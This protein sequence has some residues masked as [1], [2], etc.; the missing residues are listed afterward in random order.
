MSQA[1]HEGAVESFTVADNQREEAIQM[2]N[3][4]SIDETVALESEY[5]EQLQRGINRYTASFIIKR[6]VKVINSPLHEEHPLHGLVINDSGRKR[7]LGVTILG[8]RN[9]IRISQKFENN[10][11]ELHDDLEYKIY[12]LKPQLVG[13]LGEIAVF[14]PKREVSG[15][16]YVTYRLDDKLQKLVKNEQNSFLEFFYYAHDINNVPHI[17]MKTT[18]V[19][20]EAQE[21]A[22]L[23]RQSTPDSVA[24]FLG[25]PE[26]IP[27]SKR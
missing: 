9:A 15:K 23:L 25:P 19:E 21:Y 2:T 5:Y 10:L 26:I 1:Y 16:R 12:S 20:D 8:R 24:I 22:N 11:V 4:Q 17:T 3:E 18:Y 6:P 7:Q 13:H 27:I 14:G